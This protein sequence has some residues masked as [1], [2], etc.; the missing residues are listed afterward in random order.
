MQP[1]VR[2]LMA[3]TLEK[4]RFK[5]LGYLGAVSLRCL[6]ALILRNALLTGCIAGGDHEA[7]LVQ[8]LPVAKA[9]LPQNQGSLHP[10]PVSSLAVHARWPCADREIRQ[11]WAQ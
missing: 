1:I 5:R 10:Q 2:D 4:D 9:L 8:Q 7:P 3:K 11:I 6:R